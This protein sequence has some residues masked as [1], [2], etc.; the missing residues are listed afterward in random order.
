VREGRGTDDIR[1][2]DI[3]GVDVDGP[4]VGGVVTLQREGTTRAIVDVLYVPSRSLRQTD[5]RCRRRRQWRQWRRPQPPLPFFPRTQ[6]RNICCSGARNSRLL[7]V[8]RSE[9]VR[10]VR[11]LSVLEDANISRVLA[12]GGG[13]AAVA[14]GDGPHLVCMEYL[15]HGDLCQFLR[16]HD[17]ADVAAGHGGI[18]A[19]D[20]VL[21][22]AQAA[23]GMRYLESLN[24]VHR[25]LAAR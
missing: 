12:M 25:D 22:A 24:F 4:V 16:R 13:D 9:F 17:P 7:L 20:L 15:E 5:G 23:A 2:S 21:L 10:E 6:R 11:L 3:V 8:C 18:A 14:G 19:G 1:S